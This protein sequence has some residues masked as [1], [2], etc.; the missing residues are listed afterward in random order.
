MDMNTDY[1]MTSAANAGRASGNIP[2]TRAETADP[3]PGHMIADI[4]LGQGLR[5]RTLTPRDAALVVEA[6]GTETA[7]ALW[8][9]HPAGPYTPRD[10]RAALNDWDPAAGRQAS[11]GMLERGR[12]LGALGLMID[13]PHS[14]ELAYWVRP[15]NRRQGLAL[16]GVNAL[17][18]WAHDELGLDRIWLEA[19]PDNTPSLRLADRAG[20]Q[21]EE[22][23]PH[24]CRTWS[25]PD[26]EHDTWHD[27]M[28]WAHSTASPVT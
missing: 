9:P 24:H 15:E 18:R 26:P 7:R 17:T 12:L 25:A 14:A 2:L 27:C 8:G 20:F 19:E 28:I 5:L 13:G 16:R 1:S 10:A 11:Y 22:R 3:G 23:L 4:D 6:T 21:F